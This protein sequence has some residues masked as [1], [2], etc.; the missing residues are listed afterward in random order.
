MWKIRIL[1]GDDKSHLGEVHNFASPLPLDDWD[2]PDR[3]E[4]PSKGPTSR[5]RS[6]PQHQLENHLE[7]YHCRTERQADR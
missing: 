5:D 2:Y 4:A 7:N 6:Y 3:T 1:N